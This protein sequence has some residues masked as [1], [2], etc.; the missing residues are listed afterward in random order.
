MRILKASRR[1]YC[2]IHD[3][4]Y[5]LAL[6]PETHEYIHT[7]TYFGPIYDASNCRPVPKNESQKGFHP[8]CTLR[9]TPLEKTAREAL[10]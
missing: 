5:S 1:T 2:T 4:T 9:Q 10:E 7:I 6:L 8:K 3:T